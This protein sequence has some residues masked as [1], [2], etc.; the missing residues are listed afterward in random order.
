MRRS[1]TSL[2]EFGMV[3]V[4][5]GV[6]AVITIPVVLKSQTEARKLGCAARMRDL[7]GSVL[8]YEQS[9]GY[10][11]PAGLVAPTPDPQFARGGFDE[12]SG[13]QISW[14]VLT[15]PFQDQQEAFDRFDISI[16]FYD[17]S[18]KAIGTIIE[19][20]R[21]PSDNLGAS[22][23]VLQPLARRFALGNYAAFVSPVHGED[24]DFFPGALGGFEP[25]STN[26]QR[27][28]EIS[29]GAANSFMLSEVRRR[30][31]K[32]DETRDS[33]GAW[34]L[35]WMGSSILSVDLHTA[36]LDKI[37]RARTNQQLDNIS[38]P[39]N[40]Y[41][42]S[43]RFCQS[44]PLAALEE[45]PCT[46]YE[47]YLRGGLSWGAARSLHDGGVNSAF[48]DGR[49][50]FVTNE[51]DAVF[52]ANVVSTNNGRPVRKLPSTKAIGKQVNQP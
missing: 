52:Y 22:F 3:S 42:D 43:I 25:G 19:S 29:D 9:N 33:R 39:N 8:A 23:S 16:P 7:A 2:I 15:L 32:S 47:G 31:D 46:R 12:N 1:G 17:Q 11:P 24:A 38:T 50:R 37:Y 28:V 36:G 13:L 49:V 41:V 35:P 18:D 26:G 34:A 51:V 20:L 14:I 21:C 27:L 6:A 44:P 40:F 45:M 4:I 5:L 10:L 30:P 48:V